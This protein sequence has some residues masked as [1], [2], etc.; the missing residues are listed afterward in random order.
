MNLGAGRVGREKWGRP[1][2]RLKQGRREGG[3]V[4]N[5]RTLETR[6]AVRDTLGKHNKNIEAG[7]ESH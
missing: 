7:E 6:K 5:T 2:E 3:G 4:A 1:E